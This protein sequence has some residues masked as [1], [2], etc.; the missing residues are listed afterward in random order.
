M[1]TPSPVVNFEALPVI[2]TLKEIAGIYR[3][4]P[5]TI[6][7]GLQNGTFRPRPFEWY[8]YRWKKTD[9][10]ADLDREREERTM[11]NHG[12]RAVKARLRHDPPRRTTVARRASR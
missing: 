9:I 1:K 11:R 2:L 3:I 10:A 7:R 12:F 6:R 4:A 8:P 5:S